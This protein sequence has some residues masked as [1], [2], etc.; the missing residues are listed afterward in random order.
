MQQHMIHLQGQHQLLQQEDSGSLLSET[1]SEA[2]YETSETQ[3]THLTARSYSHQHASCV[4]TESYPYQRA[5]E[6]ANSWTSRSDNHNASGGESESESEIGCEFFITPEGVNRT[7]FEV[8]EVDLIE[9]AR[10]ASYF[11]PHQY[12]TNTATLHPVVVSSQASAA[13]ADRMTLHGISKGDS[14]SSTNNSSSGNSSSS[15][16]G[17]NLPRRFLS[18]PNVRHEYASTPLN[19]PEVPHRDGEGNLD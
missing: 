14:R 7:P 2:S 15:R 11:L 12:R 8:W 5:T 4:P 6:W 3:S 16:K 18:F 10:L 13:A 9:S 1:N 17:W 19:S